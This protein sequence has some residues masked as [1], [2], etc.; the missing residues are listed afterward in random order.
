MKLSYKKIGLFVLIG[1]FSWG[2]YEY[3]RLG[4]HTRPDMPD[5]AW[6][7]VSKS[8]TRA[9]VV[10]IPDERPER[11]YFL[12]PTAETPEWFKDAWSFCEQAT[13]EQKELN[14]PDRGMRL[15]G[16]CSI[17]ADG[18]IIYTAVLQSAPSL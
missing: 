10:D 15:E 14:P 1:I 17:N 8:G 18:E 4:L 9:I 3:F 13:D 2:I 6:S 7:I 11:K 12:M 16:F 5:G